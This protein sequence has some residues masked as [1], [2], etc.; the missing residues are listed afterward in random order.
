MKGYKHVP[1]RYAAAF[2]AGTTFVV[3]TYSYYRGLEGSRGDSLEGSVRREVNHIEI[4]REEIDANA[5]A[6]AAMGIKLTN[7]GRF[8]GSGLQHNLRLRDQYIF[9]CSAEPDD[10]YLKDHS[11]FEIADLRE[12]AAH[13]TAARRDILSGFEVRPVRY[14][15]VIGD[16]FAGQTLLPDPFVKGEEFSAEQELRIVWQSSVGQPL[17]QIMCYPAA[18]LIKRIQ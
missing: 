6:F 15:P 14:A 5:E 2:Q 8:Q 12:F 1:P 17:E 4:D 11:L 13:L 9:C 10:R 16:P 7:V 3:G 18:R